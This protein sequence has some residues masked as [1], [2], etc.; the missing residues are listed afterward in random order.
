MLENIQRKLELH[1]NENLGIIYWVYG[2]KLSC[3][4]NILERGF[5]LNL[6]SMHELP[7]VFKYNYFQNFNGQT[8]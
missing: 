7:A 4:I 2:L 5:G 6:Y 8:T 1:D 3:M